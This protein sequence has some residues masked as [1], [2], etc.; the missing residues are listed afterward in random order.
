M[1]PDSDKLIVFFLLFN[2][3]HM[4]VEVIVDILRSIT[5][6]EGP[7]EQIMVIFLLNLPTLSQLRFGHAL[8]F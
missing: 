3:L 5:S 6:P 7:Q 2:P 4:P 8:P 1:F